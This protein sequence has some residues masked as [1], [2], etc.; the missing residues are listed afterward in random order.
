[1]T[2]AEAAAA[3][4]ALPPEL[5]AVKA[6]IAPWIWVTPVVSI[7]LGFLNWYRIKKIGKRLGE[8]V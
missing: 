7:V 5:K 3:E 4:A 1:M 6:A 2:P 8:R